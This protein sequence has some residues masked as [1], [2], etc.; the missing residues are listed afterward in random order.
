MNQKRRH[1]ALET[2]LSTSIGFI[3]AMAVWEWI[4]APIYGLPTDAYVNLGITC[5]YTI[6]S[7]LRGYFVRRLFNW[8]HAKEML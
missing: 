4:V 5:I 3:V 8:L 7:I 6:I 2:V 1:S